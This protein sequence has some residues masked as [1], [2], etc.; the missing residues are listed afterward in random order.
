MVDILRNDNREV[1]LPDVFT[2]TP[3][4]LPP[5]DDDRQDFYLDGDFPGPLMSNTMQRKDLLRFILLKAQ[6]CLEYMDKEEYLFWKIMDLFCRHNGVSEY[7][8]LRDWC[9]PL[10]KLLCS[11][12]PEHREAVIKMG[13]DLA[14]RG[15]TYAAHICYV[16]AKVD[17]G[18]RSQFNIIGCKSLPFGM[19]VLTAA[20]ERTEVYEYVLS[21][22][23]GPAQTN[24]QLYKLCHASR[25]SQ[26]ELFR[27]KAFKYCETIAR[28]VITFPDRFRKSF[29]ERLISLSNKVKTPGKEFEWLQ[30]VG[31]LYG[32][33]ADAVINAVPE[34]HVTQDPE[35]DSSDEDDLSDE[36]DSSDEDDQLPDQDEDGLLLAM[37][38]PRYTIG[39]L[40]GKGAFGSV[41]TAIRKDDG[42]EVSVLPHPDKTNCTLQQLLVAVKFI[43]QKHFIKP[44]MIP[45]ETSEVHSEVAMMKIVSEPPRCSNIVELL[46]WFQ[47]PDR[48]ALVMERPSPCVNLREY[49]VSQGGRLSEDQVRDIML[50]VVRALRHCTDRG[51]L[52]RDVKA[53]NLIINTDTLE[54]KLIDFGCG[55]FLKNRPYTTFAG[56]PA[57][58]PPEW[59]LVDSYMGIPATIW[60]LGILLFVL[61][62]GNYPFKS[63]EDIENG[64]LKFSPHVSRDFIEL[65]LWCLDFRSDMRPSF[66]GF[67][68]HEW[69]TERV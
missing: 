64:H 20:I 22:T 13:D 34:Q 57:F 11:S 39:D 38:A 37:L 46:E 26:T 9:L 32:V 33:D 25:L 44:K 30:E 27:Y 14:C 4:F 29:V 68:S 28:A 61:V 50:Q 23:S 16:V 36:D 19:T 54:V 2:E 5:P 47:T 45:G 10:G 58:C 41:Y 24:F 35:S 31:Q 53:E 7:K 18:T 66:E 59:V 62:C 51:V 1:Q 67:I 48:V 42:K 63:E 56:T 8:T 55:D 40:L 60:G 52:H 43:K 6:D 69:F 21:L 15:L 17:L 65:V 12:P 3:D 49:G